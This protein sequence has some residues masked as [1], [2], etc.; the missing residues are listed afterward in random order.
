MNITLRPASSSIF[1]Q[2]LIWAE[3]PALADFFRHRGPSFT[4]ASPEGLALQLQNA[5]AIY[6][7]PVLVGVVQLSCLDFVSR[8]CSIGMLI[9][10]KFTENR[11]EIS[12]L[13]YEQTLDYCFGTL[14]M[15]KVTMKVLSTRTKLI[16]RLTQDGWTIEGHLRQNC[17]VNG[18]A[19]DEVILRLLKSERK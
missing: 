3:D 7:G 2:F 17:F 4:W 11:H 13:I 18:E 15:H 12:R 16:Q 19:R 5:F 9:D 10:S 6:E 14:Q 1:E 8:N